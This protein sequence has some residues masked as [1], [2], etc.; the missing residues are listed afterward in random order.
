MNAAAD[1]TIEK[2]HKVSIA[3]VV[4]QFKVRWFC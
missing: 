3:N 4:V 1:M 2:V